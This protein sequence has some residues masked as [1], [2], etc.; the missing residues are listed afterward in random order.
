M[1]IDE[2][3]KNKPQGATDFQDGKYYAQTIDGGWF[4]YFEGA[5]FLSYPNVLCMTKIQ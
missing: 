4:C 1:N 2:I 5:W 3:K